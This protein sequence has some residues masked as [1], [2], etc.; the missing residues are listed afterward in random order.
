[1]FCKVLSRRILNSKS[2]KIPN[3]NKIPIFTLN[4]ALSDPLFLRRELSRR[5]RAIIK[6][7][8]PDGCRK[9]MH[10]DV[11][12]ITQ[13][14]GWPHFEY[15]ARWM[16]RT[17]CVENFL[18]SVEKIWKS[19]PQANLFFVTV[20]TSHFLRNKVYLKTTSIHS[21]VF[22]INFPSHHVYWRNLR[23]VLLGMFAYLFTSF[24]ILR[25]VCWQATEI[26]NMF[27]WQDLIGKH[28]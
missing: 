5:W 4:L 22:V 25:S 10:F 17:V 23:G 9:V 28:R 15:D 24:L 12:L 21:L 8:R 14:L 18:V 20:E 6:C 13:Y 3:F 26:G 1:M 16:Q 2:D 11:L 19:V 27:W 7:K